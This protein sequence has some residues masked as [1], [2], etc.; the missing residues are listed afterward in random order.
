MGKKLNTGQGDTSKRGPGSP[1]QS[2]EDGR[3]SAAIPIAPA[4]DPDEIWDEEEPKEAI[5]G[6]ECLGC[7]NVQASY[8]NGE[9]DV[10][11]GLCIEPMYE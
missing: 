1:L 4:H 10:C 2:S 6:Y 11:C 8:H 7:G 5:F 9:C 3:I